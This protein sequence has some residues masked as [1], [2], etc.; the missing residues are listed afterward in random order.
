MPE[1]TQTPQEQVV[2]FVPWSEKVKELPNP[3]ANE[4]MVSQTWDMYEAL[5]FFYI[6]WLGTY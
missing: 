1:N 6:M 5:T 4:A 2:F 3:P